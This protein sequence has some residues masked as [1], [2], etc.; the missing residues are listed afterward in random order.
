MKVRDL[1]SELED[2]H[3]DDEVILNHHRSWICVEF[4]NG[5]VYLDAD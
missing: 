5:K 1:I 2:A 4:C 3:D